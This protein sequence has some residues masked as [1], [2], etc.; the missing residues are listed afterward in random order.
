MRSD[1]LIFCCSALVAGGFAGWFAA[2]P[3]PAPKQS[4]QANI[5]SLSSQPAVESVALPPKDDFI[6]RLHDVLSISRRIQRQRAITTIADGLS[7]ADIREALQHLDKIQLHWKERNH[8]RSALLAQWGKLDPDGAI[9]FATA[10]D[11]LSD[12]QSAVDAVLGGWIEKDRRAAEVWVTGL[13]AGP[14]K[15]SALAALVTALAVAEPAHALDLARDISF[16]RSMLTSDCVTPLVHALFDKWIDEDP[17]AAAGAAAKL[18]DTVSFRDGALHLVGK[19]WAAQDI[20][21]AFAW[22]QSLGPVTDTNE[23]QR[24]AL[25]GVLNSW[26]S[27]DPDAAIQWLNDLPDDDAK[28]GFIQSVAS[29]FQDSDPA[30]AMQLA[31]AIPPGWAREQTVDYSMRAWLS[32]DPLIAANWAVKQEDDGIR[33]VALRRV[34]AGWLSTDPASAREWIE[35]MPAGAMKD[36]MLHDATMMIAAGIQWGRRGTIPL[37]EW[38]STEAI[39]DAAAALDAIGD[40]NQRMAAYSTLAGKWLNRDAQT[41]RAWVEKLPISDAEK[42]ALLQAKPKPWPPPPP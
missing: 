38:M 25:T 18:P 20:D 4:R 11:N 10:L 21:R 17:A 14:L 29:Q 6:A 39:R 7:V 8:V 35:S 16:S 27:K 37:I 13:P 42:S 24:N 19:R 3:S 28:L 31:V 12:R 22:A 34:A 41:A 30:R 36:K 9:T 1:Q 32:N 15:K 33:Q 2:A 23:Y 26:L 40:P 5:A